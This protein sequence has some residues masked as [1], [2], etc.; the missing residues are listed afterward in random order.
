MSKIPLKWYLTND[1]GG[2]PELVRLHAGK[3]APV[4]D[5]QGSWTPPYPA[6]DCVLALTEGTG[7]SGMVAPPPGQSYALLNLAALSLENDPTGENPVEA[8]RLVLVAAGLHKAGTILR[9]PVA[10][11]VRELF[12]KAKAV[13]DHAVEEGDQ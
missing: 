3:I 8:F 11:A 7:Q 13:V 12:D 4:L 10:N 6:A 1:L 2:Q 9:A 5:G